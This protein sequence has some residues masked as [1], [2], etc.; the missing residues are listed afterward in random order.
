M[1]FQKVE[2]TRYVTLA[3]SVHNN[4]TEQ[5]ET[6]QTTEPHTATVDI[7]EL[8]VKAIE[9]LHDELLESSKDCTVIGATLVAEQVRY[10]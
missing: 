10:A 2:P 9:G 5:V 6:Y 1:Q 8:I 7:R 4:I 3:L